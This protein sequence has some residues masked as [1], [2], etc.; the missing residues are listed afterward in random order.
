MRMA[1]DGLQAPALAEQAVVRRSQRRLTIRRLVI[2]SGP[3]T[4]RLPTTESQSMRPFETP[5]LT[6]GDLDADDGRAR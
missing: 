6:L 4:M 5:Q 2:A 3:T 1:S